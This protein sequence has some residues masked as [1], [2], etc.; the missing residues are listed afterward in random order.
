MGRFE[1]YLIEYSH[2]VRVSQSSFQ[3]EMPVVE[4]KLTHDYIES[5]L[6]TTITKE[7]IITILQKLAFEVSELD[8]LYTVQ[9]PAHRATKDVGIP[10]DIVEEIARMY[11]Y[12]NIPSTPIIRSNNIVQENKRIS[13][14]RSLRSFLASQHLLEC[15]NYSFSNQQDN[16][17]VGIYDHANSIALLNS[18]NEEH[19]HMRRHMLPWM[20]HCIYENTRRA[21]AFW[22]FEIGRIHKKDDSGIMYESERVIITTRGYSHATNEEIL[23]RICDF[24]G[25]GICIT[26]HDATHFPAYHP[27]KLAIVP[28][29]EE[30]IIIAGYVHPN[31][32]RQYDL[33]DESIFSI[34]IDLGE[35]HTIST[36][37]VV[38][39]P[40]SKFQSTTR[41]LNFVTPERLSFARLSEV[42][43]STSPLLENIVHIADYRD[44]VKLWIGN[45]SRT[46]SFEIISPDHTLTDEELSDIQEQIISNVEA[47]TMA[48]LRRE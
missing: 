40:L 23:Q 22:L 46:L 16:E 38:Y 13:L 35:F 21:S 41:E 31:T 12:E 39:K 10:A 17:H 11:G 19:T 36:K 26:P 4:I 8:S 30:P 15:Y 44:D 34:E 27:W 2:N 48:R 14:I 7:K 37:T 45:I 1:D 20:L 6:G 32:L 25:G 29:K 28:G 9:V 42:I 43:Q 18:T 33:S 5:C 24:I 47:N 3:K